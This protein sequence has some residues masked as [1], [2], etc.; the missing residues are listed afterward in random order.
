MSY[1]PPRPRIG[2]RLK[3]EVW[4]K[5]AG[6]CQLCG[7]PILPGETFHIDHELARELGGSDG[8]ENLRLAHDDCHRDKTR[9]DVAL[10]AKSNRVRKRHMTP[11]EPRK[12]KEQRAK[13]RGR[14]TIQSRPFPK[15]REP[16]P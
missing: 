11:T 4:E 2:K 12:P 16:T 13:I 10:I 8:I 9:R 14:A 1:A 6:C 3:A 15:R 7:L 5:D